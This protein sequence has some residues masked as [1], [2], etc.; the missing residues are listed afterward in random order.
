MFNRNTYQTF[1][2]VLRIAGSLFAEKGYDDT[3][4]EA[5][6]EASGIPLDEIIYRFG[7]K[8][9][10]YAEVFYM[11]IESDRLLSVDSV[12]REHPNWIF[13]HWGRSRIIR[14]K[15]RYLYDSMFSETYPWKTALMA[16]EMSAPVLRGENQLDY[17]F[18]QII[19]DLECFYRYIR[20]DLSES[21][22][23]Y[24][25]CL[26]ITYINFFL[27]RAPSSAKGNGHAPEDRARRH[28][29]D[30]TTT[31]VLRFLGL[32]DESE[33]D[34]TESREFEVL[35]VQYSGTTRP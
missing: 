16:R 33:G 27:L 35:N 4:M 22:L 32:P 1:K 21:E 7:G 24:C 28:L 2:K 5:I 11:L 13:T 30:F 6:A 34:S 23:Y 15:I 20:P 14:Q 18:R 25:C 26:P 29:A 8:D 9:K 12:I 17:V 31:V 10:L 3:S 19:G